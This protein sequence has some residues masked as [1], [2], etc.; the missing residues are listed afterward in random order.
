M[1][2]DYKRQFL[3]SAKI[4][5]PEFACVGETQLLAI[6]KRQTRPQVWMERIGG[7]GKVKV[8]GHA[9]VYHQLLAA[10]EI[11]ENVLGTPPHPGYFAARESL[12]KLCAGRETG[13]AFPQKGGAFRKPSPGQTFL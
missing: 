9:Q 3:G 12:G 8:P 5:P 4:E 2:R 1:Q 6:D 10:V 7:I 11:R 13:R